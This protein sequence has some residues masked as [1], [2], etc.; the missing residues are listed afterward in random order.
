VISIGKEEILK[1][2]LPTIQ[3]YADRINVPLI[4]INKPKYNIDKNNSNYNYLTF[5]KNQI[6]DLFDKYDRVL[7]LDSDVI[8]KE[9]CPNLFH[10]DVGK[11]Y[12]VFEDVGSKKN[13]RKHQIKTIKKT[14]GDIPDWTEEYFNSGVI[15][16]DKIHKESF[17]IDS[18]NIINLNLGDF[19]EQN[20]LNWLTRA[21]EFS[22]VNLG[23]KYNHMNFFTEEF[24]YNKDDSFILHY[25]GNQKIKINNMKNDFKKYYKNEK[26]T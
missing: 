15:L 20:Y 1:Y 11:F 26:R 9:D 5:E 14:L 25:A 21:H 13:N 7:R 18:K 23:H 8:I 22:I 12:C 3:K 16:C 10:N 17:N 2:S 6:Y 24:K 19:K 4:V